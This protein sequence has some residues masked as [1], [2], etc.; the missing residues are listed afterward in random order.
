VLEGE[1]NVVA[2]SRPEVPRFL[3]IGI[4][5]NEEAAS[6]RAHGRSR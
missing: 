3:L 5:V 6:H 1:A 2:I 4:T